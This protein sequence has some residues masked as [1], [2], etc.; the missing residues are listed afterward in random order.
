[1]GAAAEVAA[2]LTFLLLLLP[3]LKDRALA[4][5][6][7]GVRGP[8]EALAAAG[9]P[10]GLGLLAGAATGITAGGAGLGGRHG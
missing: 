6:A 8:D 10:L 7:A 3:M 1:M 2:P 4:Y 5:V 9:L